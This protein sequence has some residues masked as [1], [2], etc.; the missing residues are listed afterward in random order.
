MTSTGADL[1]DLDAFCAEEPFVRALAKSLLFDDA[2]ADDVVQQTWLEAL[3]RKVPG[4]D[5]RRGWLARVVRSRA[6]NA[7]R[8]E[9]RLHERER[10]A[11][12]PEAVES[13]DELLAREEQRRIV[14]A[15]VAA[16]PEPYRS[17]VMLR[18]FEGHEPRAI[19]R[20]QSTPIETVHTRLK[21]ARALLRERLDATHGGDRRAWM[22]ALVPLAA[23][24]NAARGAVMAKLLG[25]FALLTAMKP[26]LVVL[27]GIAL[28]LLVAR[29]SSDPDPSAAPAAPQ[30]VA[31]TDAR[32]ADV[33]HATPPSDVAPSTIARAELAPPSPAISRDDGLD[34]TQLASLTGRL[35]DPS[36]APAAARRCRLLCIDPVRAHPGGFEPGVVADGAGISA[37]ETSTGEDGRFAF[38]DVPAGQSH[39][40]WL[41]VGAPHANLRP[42]SFELPAGVTTD[43]GTLVLETRGSITGRI[44]GEDGA[45]IAGALV[46]ALDLP[47][48]L[49]GLAPIDRLEA[50]GALFCALPDPGDFA[51]R[52][53]GARA[54]VEAARRALS[55][56]VPQADADARFAVLP[57]PRWLDDAWRALPI[58]SATTDADGRFVIEGLV[59]GDH[60]LLVSADGF[61]R[62]T[63]TR[64]P[65]R[66]AERRDTGELR[67]ARGESLACRVL[68]A[69]A[70][71]V[72]GAEL[73]VAL[74]PR[75]G[76]TGVLFAEPVR[77]SDAGGRAVFD[78]LPRGEY[79]VAFR[80]GPAA[81]WNTVAPVD[82]GDD[83]ELRLPATRDVA[84]RVIDDAGNGV[85]GARFTLWTGPTLGEAT[86]AGLQEEVAS[87]VEPVDPVEGGEPG[88]FTLRALEPDVYTLGVAADG[89]ALAQRLLVVDP[90]APADAAPITVTL[91]RG[92]DC[93]VEVVDDA[94][95]PVPGA[96][97]WIHAA[98]DE[99]SAFSQSILYSYGGFS[100]WDR[101][102]RG[103]RRTD[104][105][106]RVRIASLPRGPAAVLVRHRARGSIG[107]EVAE[108]GAS[109][110]VTLPRPGRIEG[111]VRRSG[112]VPAPDSLRLS[113]APNAASNG[114][115]FPVASHGVVVR[116]D[117]SFVAESLAPGTWRVLVEDRLGRDEQRARSIG[118]LVMRANPTGWFVREPGTTEATAD[119]VPGGVARVAL[120]IDPLAATPGSLGATLRGRV[121]IDGRARAGLAI[122]ARVE[123]EDWT[124]REVPI[125]TTDAAGR[126]ERTALPPRE[127]ELEI[128]FDGDAPFV[129]RKTVAASEGVTVDADFT[130][131]T[132]LLE[133]VVHSTGDAPAAE[134]PVWI[135]GDAGAGGSIHARATADGRGLARA[136]LPRGRYEVY[137]AN[138][139]GEA[140]VTG[141]DLRE[142][143][144]HELKLGDDRY[145]R[146]R[147]AV[148]STVR[149]ESVLV[150]GLDD[151]DPQSIRST[152]FV[153][154]NDRR[155]VAVGKVDAGRYRIE[156]RTADGS[157][158]ADPETITVAESG[159]AEFVLRLGARREE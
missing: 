151:R 8:G 65:L 130:S 18:Y 118:A 37:I 124:T 136:R 11:A 85:A 31:D 7:R 128:T 144:R 6:S 147:F 40:L 44:V 116:D 150:S 33:A 81:R 146:L 82:S 39:A 41:G 110:R 93:T 59:D 157:F 95:A 64:V 4:G 42:L 131:T 134:C 15:A 154:L 139:S 24:R 97:V 62:A 17:V 98:A 129:W 77:R 152:H 73:R 108:L 9:R 56:N 153:L 105:E 72:A 87:R 138:E 132:A 117:G 34:A 115:S 127:F 12:R 5:A 50:G 28:A 121:E 52:K 145:L 84:L 69:S 137:A 158:A 126:F 57:F 149:L 38:R 63:K 76:L 61:A 143:Q 26:F 99:H 71:P 35:V 19:A 104:G 102:A 20:L 133:I 30:I 3:R 107:V 54:F 58:P 29:L 66:N 141:V 88:R 21:R 120:E 96:E 114:A 125:A 103:G 123:G 10:A 13:P 1:H 36:G 79:V 106:G 2:Q 14:V 109:L 46:R 74:R 32:R 53:D 55:K 23:A 112:A 140:R 100:A 92:I 90:K 67:L 75:A 68:D 25:L 43:L 119:V 148:D 49:L 60:A 156:L 135:S 22:L 142:D 155:E 27:A 91:V 111:T 80:R 48:A 83:V 16:L 159:P 86:A 47:G 70:A 94:G 101:L 113:V 89:H 122:L 45:P 78:A 51:A